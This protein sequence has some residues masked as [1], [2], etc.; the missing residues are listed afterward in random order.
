MRLWQSCGYQWRSMNAFVADM[1]N[2]CVGSED[3]QMASRSRTHKP[4][5]KRAVAPK[6]QRKAPFTL[7]QLIAPRIRAT[8]ARPHLR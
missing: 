4:F 8:G 5:K 3:L 6:P 7:A 2:E 1:G